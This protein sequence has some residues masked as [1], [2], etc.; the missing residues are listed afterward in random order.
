M[1][2]GVLLQPVATGEGATYLG[3]I[4]YGLLLTAALTLA[5]WLLALLLG[6]V[7]G[8]MRAWPSRLC[9]AVGATYVSVFRKVPLIAQ[10]SIWYFVSPELLPTVISDWI[11]SITPCVQ[12]FLVSGLA[13]GF[14]TG[15][16]ICE[17]VRAGI[18]SL[19]FGQMQAALAIG[20]TLPQACCHI[21]TPQCF[22]RILPP[23]TP[24]FL[25][26]S[27]NSAVASTIGLLELSGQ[28]QQLVDFTAQP[29]ESFIVVTLA[30]MGLNVAILRIMEW[31]QR[32]TRLPG[33]MGH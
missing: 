23:L 31:I 16:R 26:I 1:E 7:F 28:A 14:F 33:V 10:F 21:L 32:R 25:S 24:E 22:R 17:Q 15:A 19:P 11:K 29:Y 20:F 3:W 4:L 13:F 5:A 9:D 12:V 6:S 27:K 18:A 8:I 2:L 30:Y